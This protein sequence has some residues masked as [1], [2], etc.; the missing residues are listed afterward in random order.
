MPGRVGGKVAIVTGGGSGIGAETAR[1]LARE[2]AA[3][4]V[5]DRNE[6]G[7]NEVASQIIEAGGTALGIAVDVAK[8]ADV[9]SMVSAAVA[10]FGRLDILHNNAAAMDT[11]ADDSDVVNVDLS[12]WD[13]VM[14][15]NLRG[16]FLG[17]RFAIPAMIKTGAGSIVNTSSVGAFMGDLYRCAYGTSKGGLNSLTRYVSTAYGHR[18][19]RCNAVLP[20]LVLTESA[21]AARSPA[22]IE[23]MTSHHPLGLAGPEDIANVVLFLASDD[24]RGVTGQLIVADRG[25]TIHNPFYAYSMRA[26][27][28]NSPADLA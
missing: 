12:L 3:V 27:V 9:E 26:R 14:R 11:L 17:C 23:E 13:D 18:G 25:L 6:L 2:G 10:T 1:L 20:A 5:A 22:E 4:L 8:E 28:E 7:A 15:I 21:R 24:S 16:P 19:I